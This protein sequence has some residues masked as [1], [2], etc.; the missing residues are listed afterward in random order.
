MLIC[1]VLVALMVKL[2]T[3]VVKPEQALHLNGVMAGWGAVQVPHRGGWHAVGAASAQGAELLLQVCHIVGAGGL[4]AGGVASKG[5]GTVRA[6]RYIVM[7]RSHASMQ[8][9]ASLGCYSVASHEQQRLQV[10]H[11]GKAARTGCVQL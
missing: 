4:G 6:L 3:H 7:L 2:L 5:W 9:H 10:V 8:P 11:G 1:L